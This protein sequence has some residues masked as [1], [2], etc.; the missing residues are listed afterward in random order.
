MNKK[1]LTKIQIAIILILGY[2]WL[3]FAVWQIRN[4]KANSATFYT[5]YKD[6]ITFNKISKFE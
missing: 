3:S 1:I 6:M 2:H 4:P 5:Y